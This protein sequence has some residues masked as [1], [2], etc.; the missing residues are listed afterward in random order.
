MV[1]HFG[2]VSHRNREQ[3]SGAD[4]ED[5]IFG[6][7][8]GARGQAGKLLLR[9]TSPPL[10]NE[11]AN[12]ADLGA[13]MNTLLGYALFPLRPFGDQDGRRGKIREGQKFRLEVVWRGEA[14]LWDSVAALVAV[15][16]HLGWLGFRGRRAFGALQLISPE[17]CLWDALS[18]FW[19]PEHVRILELPQDNLTDGRQTAARLLVWYRSWRHPG[20]RGRR[21]DRQS[22]RWV[23]IPAQQQ[24]ENRAQPGFAYA[25]R[26]HN[27]GLAVQGTGAPNPDPENP[28]GRA[29][30][31][32]RPALGLPMIQYFSSLGDVQGPLHRQRATVNWDWEWDERKQKG[33]GRF[34]SPVILRPYKDAH[35]RWHALVIFAGAHQWPAGKEVHLSCAGRHQTRRVSLDLYKAMKQGPRLRP[36]L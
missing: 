21:W 22:R 24:A 9:I 11:P 5:L 33:T 14:G 23:D 15:W 19:R 10:E 17:L 6:R 32:F 25:R 34:A 27:E 3:G 30:E 2:R 8:A 7:T 35:V 26:D 28:R 18:H 1:P 20:Q 4:Q 16:G 13:G 29:G 12:A 31:S 36:F